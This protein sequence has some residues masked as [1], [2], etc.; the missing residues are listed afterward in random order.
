MSWRYLPFAAHSHEA[1]D[2]QVYAGL[3]AVGRDREVEVLHDLVFPLSWFVQKDYVTA[4]W[5]ELRSHHVLF[6]VAGD[7]EFKSGDDV[8][9]Q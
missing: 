9:R 5:H 1:G 3:E 2:G 7:D 8:S 4:R 6:A